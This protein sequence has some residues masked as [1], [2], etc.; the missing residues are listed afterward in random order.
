MHVQRR[1]A[2]VLA[3]AALVLGAPASARA[4]AVTD[5]Y[6]NAQT[7]ILTPA[8]TA[9]AS[10]LSF[11]M[12]QG[13]VYDA[14][15]AI[16]GGYTPYL[17][18]PRANPWD[19]K[20][21]A[22]A[23]AAF[24]VLK[25]LLPAQLPT[26]QAQYDASLLAIRDG[27]KKA[28]GI[29]VG[30]AAAAA[31][32]AARAND[33]RGGPFTFVVGTT[34]GAWRPSPPNFGFEPTPWVGNVTPFL[35]PN[36]AMLRTK[37]PNPVTSRR[38]AR[39]FNEVKS[40]GSLTSTTRTAD[41]TMAALFWQDYPGA[42]WGRLA[43]ALSARNGL[44]MADNARLFARISLTAADAAIGCWNDKYYWNFWRP[45]V[46]IRE[47]GTDGNPRTEADLNWKPLFDPATVT[48][49]PLVTPTFPDHPSGHSCLSSSVL[50]TFRDFFN[51]DRMEISVTSARFPGQARTFHR[52]SDV[53]D[54]IINARVWGGIHF[55]EAD[56][57]GAKLGKKVAKWEQRHY[58]K[59]AHGHHKW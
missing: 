41:Q 19:S 12:V 40:I 34:P 23:A 26:L 2:L 7:A 11:A 3:A 54:E 6:S 49:A 10:A 13:A 5:W 18:K 9:H 55:R 8:P 28:S 50:N 1:S 43:T 56:E 46:A 22:V 27:P 58:F 4:D 42:I 38:Y 14:V 53:L 35:V 25:V 59:R 31:M 15:N 57:Q 20:E 51:S 47:A 16:D 33:G 44:D 24:D 17:V 45:I 29:R 36:A 32:L 48:T 37:G 39:D 30:Q 21:A 52:F